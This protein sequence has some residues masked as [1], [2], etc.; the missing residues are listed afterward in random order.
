[1]RPRSPTAQTRFDVPLTALSVPLAPLNW[2][3]NVL[4]LQRMMRLS[5]GSPGRVVPPT[6]YTSLA[7]RPHT[8]LKW[9]AVESVVA[10]SGQAL[11]FHRRM[12]ARSPATQTSLL[13]APQSAYSERLVPLEIGAHDD[14]LQRKRPPPSAQIQASLVDTAQSPRRANV[15]TKGTAAH[16]DA[17]R[18]ASAVVGLVVTLPAVQTSVG[19]VPPRARKVAADPGTTGDSVIPFQ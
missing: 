1:M 7:E 17:N 13:D 2:V 4:L 5:G 9:L 14:T 6:K 12:V 8:P 19:P 15:D 3:V 16:T 18:Y 11:P 10:T